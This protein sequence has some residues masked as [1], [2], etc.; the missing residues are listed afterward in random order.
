MA[1]SSLKKVI[2]LLS[3]GLFLTLVQGQSVTSTPTK[4]SVLT[5]TIAGSVVTYSPQF[6][7][8]AS[9]NQGAN[10][11]PNIRDPEGIDAQSVCPGYKASNIVENSYGFSARLSLAGKACNV[12]GT[13]IDNLN[14]DVQFQ[15]ADRVSVRI[16]PTTVDASN[17][18]WYI[19]PENLVPRP[20]LDDDAGSTISKNDLDITWSNDP[21]FSFTV[22]R[23]STGD[24]VFSTKGS[25]LVYE[26]QFIEFVTS[27]PENYNVYGLG[28]QIH[29]FR[30][31]NNYT[32]T[33]YA[34][35]AGDPVD[36]N[37]YSSHPFYLDTRYFEV[38][39]QTGNK[40]LVTSNDPSSTS[41]Y[42][43]ISHGVF[44]RNA[45]GQEVLLRAENITWRTLGG[46]I[47]LFFFNGPSQPEV[48]KQYQLGAIGLP[49]MQQYFTF[50]YHQCRWGYMNWTN[51]QEVVDNFAKFNIP[52]ENIW[53]DIDYM[54]S[55]RD[56]DMDPNT[57][58]VAEGKQ[59]LD[60]LHGRSHT[61][62]FIFEKITSLRE[63]GC[64][65]R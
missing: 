3:S 53:T 37:I 12:Y 55:Y 42:E 29:G 58:P 23:K 15:N 63:N 52:L 65:W 57:F 19:L 8:P 61:T 14:L 46:S 35:D 60:K 34:A 44:L 20:G 17:S 21:T 28:E 13:D 5:A 22:I 32:A 18:S 16:T 11:L 25:N 48:T 54:K 9:A 62:V 36:G 10:L 59:F 30:L 6:T 56:F 24:T 39:P 49:A 4:V 31:G 7:V 33:I 38:D 26:D 50:G 64:S 47:D 41:T 2:G 1:R 45:H 27:M 43:S 40:T 51:L